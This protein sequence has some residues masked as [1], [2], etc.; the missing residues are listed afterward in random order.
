MHSAGAAKVYIKKKSSM[1]ATPAAAFVQ[2]ALEELMGCFDGNS[3]ERC[4]L[5]IGA[6]QNK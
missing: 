3:S 4:R 1:C 6:H 2:V 5:I